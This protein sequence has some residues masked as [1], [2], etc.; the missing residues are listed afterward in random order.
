[1]A[2]DLHAEDVGY[3]LARQISREGVDRHMGIAT[4]VHLTVATATRVT[5]L[6]CQSLN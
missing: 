1:L 3:I 5:A 4:A 2:V 6:S